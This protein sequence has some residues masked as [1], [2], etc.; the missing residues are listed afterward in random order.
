MDSPIE[1]ISARY[2]RRY[3]E[4][5]RS[6]TKL[7]SLYD[8]YIRRRE[9]TLLDAVAA[10]AAV[11]AL[12]FSD[13]I[14][15]DRVTPP[16]VEA[17][18]RAFP[19][20]DLGQRLGELR[21]LE[22]GSPEVEGF[23]SN[24]KGVYHEVLIRDRLIDGCQVGRVVLGEGQ[25]AV[26]AEE[27]NQPGMDLRI[28]NADGTEDLLLQAKA[29]SDVSLLNE[30]LQKYPDIQILATDEVAGQITDERVF[31]SGFSN[32][33]LRERVEAPMEELWDGPVEELV[34]TALPGLPFVI[35]LTT[36]GTRVLM[37]R[38]S[39]QA[40]MRN[41]LERGVK[42]GTAMGVGMLMALAGAG[43]FSLPATL[44]TRLGL[45][46]AQ[47]Y[48]RLASKIEGDRAKL[49]ELGRA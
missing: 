49:L 32:E 7:R 5:V 33:D 35:M 10:T 40:A 12:F 19:G 15:I 3:G 9:S 46:R 1:G 23:L 47:I 11:D 14:D 42:T 22:P 21:D 30:A 48:S 38:Q 26:L 24:W 36:E 37:G 45:S 34:E 18:A 25:K 43:M 44:L 41:T 16:M 6:S 29:T 2:T 13:Q 31:S 17:F 4:A 28:L 39:Y 27:L 20:Q 8:G